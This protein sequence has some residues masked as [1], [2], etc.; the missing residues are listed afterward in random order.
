MNESLSQQNDNLPYRLA[1]YSTI[2]LPFGPAGEKSIDDIIDVGWRRNGASGI[3]SVLYCDG[4]YFTQI[5]EGARA[6]VEAVFRSILRDD[7]HEDIVVTARG[8][9]P[10][11]DFPWQPMAFVTV[12]DILATLGPG[13]MLPDTPERQVDHFASLMRQFLERRAG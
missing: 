12:A 4:A 10:H 9:V 11:R 5:L 7:R 6:D 8:H 3:T 2:A 1:F 13:A